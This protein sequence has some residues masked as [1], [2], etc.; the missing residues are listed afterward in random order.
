MVTNLQPDPSD[1]R[2]YR[3]PALE[4]DTAPLSPGVPVYMVVEGQEVEVFI[5]SHIT[6]GRQHPDFDDNT[7]LDLTPYGAYQRG[8][9][10][11]HA[12]IR[13]NPD[14]FLVLTDLGSSN[15]TFLNNERLHPLTRHIITHGDEIRLG[16]MVLQVY[17]PD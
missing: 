3:S 1:H 4:R 15:G 14:N 12:D 17:F 7:L 13:R 9:S 10:R 16:E 11:R 5:H 8:I 6:L 2:E